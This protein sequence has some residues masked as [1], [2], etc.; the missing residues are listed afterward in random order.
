MLWTIQVCPSLALKL[1]ETQSKRLVTIMWKWKKWVTGATMSVISHIQSERAGFSLTLTLRRQRLL[2]KHSSAQTI[3][4]TFPQGTVLSRRHICKEQEVTWLVRSSCDFSGNP[5]Q[6][7][8][9]GKMCHVAFSF[10]TEAPQ[11]SS[12]KDVCAN[13]QSIFTIKVL[14][15]RL[16]KI[17][18]LLMSLVLCLYHQCCARSI[19]LSSCWPSVPSSVE[20]PPG[21]S[22]QSSVSRLFQHKNMSFSKM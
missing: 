1:V 17:G 12:Q 20:S 14:F 7:L 6:S 5:R 15:N 8:I 10:E 11:T 22:L 4:Q 21:C 13:I 2:F 16:N 19:L 18:K 9:A 3:S